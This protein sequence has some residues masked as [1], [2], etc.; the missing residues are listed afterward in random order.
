MSMNRGLFAG[1]AAGVSLLIAASAPAGEGAFV[2]I[3]PAYPDPVAG[4]AG[5][6]VEVTVS[7]VGNEG[8]QAC[9][10]S[11]PADSAAACQEFQAGF[12]CDDGTWDELSRICD[13]T[14]CSCVAA[15]QNDLIVSPPLS[16][17][18][19]SEGEPDCE[20]IPQFWDALF[21]QVDEEGGQRLQAN[22]PGD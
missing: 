21:S 13:L 7:V 2:S 12:N 22:L 18:Q 16:I 8:W 11:R 4:S 1:I 10:I 17:H 6:T 5:D 14:F 3:N 20:V 19:N 15:T 9:E